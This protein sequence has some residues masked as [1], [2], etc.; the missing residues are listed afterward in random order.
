MSDARTHLEPQRCPRAR[1]GHRGRDVERTAGIDAEQSARQGSPA[2]AR[3]HVRLAAGS[4]ARAPAP[5]LLL[6][7]HAAL[8]CKEGATFVI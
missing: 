5:W 3:V 2:A 8:P 1:A 7:V 4:M 6:L